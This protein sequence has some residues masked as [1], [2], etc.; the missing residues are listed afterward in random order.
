VRLAE[1]L[2]RDAL[3]ERDDLV[4]TLRA[5]VSAVIV[6]AAPGETGLE[7][8]IRGRL[9]E[10]I[11]APRAARSAGGPSGSRRLLPLFPTRRKSAIFPPIVR[12]ISETRR[13]VG[14]NRGLA[15]TDTDIR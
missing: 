5:L 14:S 9:S 11:E 2:P 7:I 6:Q 4:D 15:T 1:L 13:M 3:G 8:K 12:L 10:L